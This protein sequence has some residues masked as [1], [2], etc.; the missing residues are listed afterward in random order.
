[1]EA[2][3]QNTAKTIEL[4]NGKSEIDLYPS[5]FKILGSKQNA[6]AIREVYNSTNGNSIY[7]KDPEAYYPYID[8]AKQDKGFKEPVNKVEKQAAMYPLDKNPYYSP[9]GQYKVLPYE[10]PGKSTP[11]TMSDLDKVAASP[12]NLLYLKKQLSAINLRENLNAQE[13]SSKG[14]YYGDSRPYYD[15]TIEDT[16]TEVKDLQNKINDMEDNLKRKS[17]NKLDLK[18]ETFTIKPQVQNI[19]NY[20][21]ESKLTHFLQN[22][23]TPI[24]N[25]KG[26]DTEFPVGTLIPKTTPKQPVTLGTKESADELSHS[27]VDAEEVPAGTVS[28]TG[29]NL[30]KDT[31]SEYI[32]AS[33]SLRSKKNIEPTVYSFNNVPVNRKTNKKSELENNLN[34]VKSS[35]DKIQENKN[36]KKK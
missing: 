32:E 6:D 27:F 28:K 10:T 19:Q 11:V 26:Y 20:I 12:E 4:V 22:Y 18:F 1:M 35:K 23:I 29:N 5:K 8:E 30:K 25:Y 9:L 2:I 15:P 34:N 17:E 13:I 3:V 31:Y 21:A 36:L 7:S 24:Q 16:I 33:N 14:I